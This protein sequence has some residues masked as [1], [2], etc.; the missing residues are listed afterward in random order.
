[1]SIRSGFGPGPGSGT[2]VGTRVTAQVRLETI[3][4]DEA[5]QD[6]AEEEDEFA[7]LAAE[8]EEDIDAGGSVFLDGDGGVR[9]PSDYEWLD[10]LP[11]I[12]Q[13]PASARPPVYFFID[14][15]YRLHSL[16]RSEVKP[17]PV[18]RAIALAIARHL[19]LSNVELREPGAWRN[20]PF[21]GNDARLRK[22]AISHLEDWLE[23]MPDG[24]QLKFAS[25]LLSA[26]EKKKSGRELPTIELR[27]LLSTPK[28]LVPA[29]RRFDELMDEL[30]PVVEQLGAMEVISRF[31]V[32]SE[33]DW[34]VEFAPHPDFVS[35]SK[36]RIGLN[37]Y[38][39]EYKAFGIV[40]ANGDV[41]TPQALICLASKKRRATRAAALR[42]LADAKA[43]G[44][45]PPTEVAGEP[46]DKTLWQR[47][48]DSQR[49]SAAILQ[50]L[51]EGEARN[52]E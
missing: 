34:Q 46:W 48:K 26:L 32:K 11:L 47:F 20:I 51:A 45:A 40:L 14:E 29:P 36:L 43:A 2:G 16:S 33:E 41:I 17:S 28:S 13:L 31:R 52:E 10:A 42:A 35:S 49:K 27:K 37:K 9:G 21:I 25:A 15:L 19:E 22:L 44:L 5:F 23:S 50:T 1:M 8:P 18:R 30:L 12:H 39:E 4:A 3:V 24:L 38:G 7:P 6:A